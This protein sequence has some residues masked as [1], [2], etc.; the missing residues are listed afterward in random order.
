MV[1]LVSYDMCYCFTVGGVL[2]WQM[3][4]MLHC[5]RSSVPLLCR[6][7]PAGNV[8]DILEKNR[9]L[10]EENRKLSRE[11]SEAVSQTAHMFE[12]FIVVRVRAP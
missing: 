1:W 12:R 3:S 11:L 10:Q 9:S 6:V 8:S 5:S 4:P 2:M 7:E